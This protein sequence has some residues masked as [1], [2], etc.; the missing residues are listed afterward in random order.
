MPVAFSRTETD[1]IEENY[2]TKSA[3]KIAELLTAE[4]GIERHSSGV[5]GWAWKVGLKKGK[6]SRQARDKY[7]AAIE[8]Y[9]PP[10]PRIKPTLKNSDLFELQEKYGIR[11]GYIARLGNLTLEVIQDYIHQG[12]LPRWLEDKLYIYI[13]DNPQR[14]N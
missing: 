9:D 5:W 11:L 13:E 14:A 4:S 1:I 10:M 6:R 3:R 7:K 2:T 12:G 8:I